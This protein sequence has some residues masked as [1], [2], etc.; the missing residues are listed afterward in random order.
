MD[1]R[2]VKERAA[3][4]RRQLSQQ[5]RAAVATLGG[6]PAYRPLSASAAAAGGGGGAATLSRS[7]GPSTAAGYAEPQQ[8]LPPAAGASSSASS[9]SPA[10]AIAAAA[11]SAAV[12]EVAQ[13]HAKVG[14]LESALEK[15]CTMFASAGLSAGPDAEFYAVSFAA[16]PIGMIVAASDEGEIEV[17][18]L[19]TDKE[20][21]PLLALASGRVAVGDTVV[22]INGHY[23]A[24]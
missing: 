21:K 15:V 24:R 16:G 11:A 5:R 10:D 7:R 17:A 13:L 23:L 3:D 19:R 20:G 12:V 1:L 8:L 14:S 18:E 2:N 22:A 6:A 4:A 9:S